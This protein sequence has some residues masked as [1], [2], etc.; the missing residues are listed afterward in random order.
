M[1]R[2]FC[3]LNARSTEGSDDVKERTEAQYTSLHPSNLAYLWGICKRVRYRAHTDNM[4]TGNAMRNTN[5]RCIKAIESKHCG[6]G[7]H[8]SR[9]I[10]NPSKNMKLK[11][12]AL[13]TDLKGNPITA[14]KGKNID[15]GNNI[16]M[17]FVIPSFM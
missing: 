12:R 1:R 2:L 6:A 3:G 10:S 7:N 8:G 5:E 15:F 17:G 9:K 11:T 4:E 14:S 16:T 13:L